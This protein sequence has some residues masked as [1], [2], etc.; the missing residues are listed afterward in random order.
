MTTPAALGRHVNHDPR[1][2][3][4]PAATATNI[5][6][7]IWAHNA[8]VLDQ[9]QVGSCTGNALAQCLN[10][11]HFA[12]ARGKHEGFLDENDALA[13]YSA[14]TKIDGIPG[15]YPPNDT[16]SSGL[17]VAKAGKNAGY[18][19]GYRH[20]FGLTHALQALQ[21]SPVIVGTAWYD[22]MFDPDTDGRVHIGGTIAGGHEWLVLGVDVPASEIIALNSWG[23]NWGTGGRF[24]MS[25]TDFG[26]LLADQGDVTVP[27]A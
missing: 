16:G 19:T 18:L 5:R 7:V 2:R 25:F 23:E 11:E 6:S 9:G 21:R 15:V 14:A 13:L 8:P 12:A 24:R 26:R 22:A 1:S 10:T 17:A 27:L 20:A 4:Y 3:A